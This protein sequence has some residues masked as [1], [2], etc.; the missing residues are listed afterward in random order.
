MFTKHCIEI[1][2]KTGENPPYQVCLIIVVISMNLFTCLLMRPTG[3]RK[4]G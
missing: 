2:L 1:N 4:Q 3:G